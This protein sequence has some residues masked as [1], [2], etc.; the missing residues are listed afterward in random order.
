MNLQKPEPR[1]KG[2]GDVL[3]VHSMFWTIQGEGPFAG[4]R[5]LF[6][7]LAGCNLQ[8]PGCD[9]EYTAGRELME[10][11]EIVS[12]AT[13]IFRVNGVQALAEPPLI[14]ITGGEPLR[15]PIGMLVDWL[16]ERGY[17]VQIES[18]GVF[19]PDPDLDTLLQIRRDKLTLVV[20]PKTTRVHP[21]AAKL[22]SAF[23]YVL[24]HRSVDE[25][26]GLPVEALQ[27]RASIGVARPPKH[28]L[29]AFNRLVPTPVYLNPFDAQDAEHN[30]LN[31]AAVAH[32]CM[33]HG[34]ILGVQIH[35]LI[36]LA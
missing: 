28:V 17:P 24:D 5:A 31:L 9:T 22:A 33:S 3:D 26:D 23:K 6:I 21:R 13:S 35:K 20:S 19:A 2:D 34:Y 27:H 18:N 30:K 10:V 12:E 25:R 8:C 32:S 15:Q 14:V 4:H 36:G 7:R 16:L 1:V 11:H 29:D